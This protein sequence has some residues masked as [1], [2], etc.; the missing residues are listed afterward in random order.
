[1]VRVQV[2]DKV[3]CH[4]W[5]FDTAGEA[6]WSEQ[7]YGDSWRTARVHGEVKESL[8]RDGW[9][10]AWET[11]DN[12]EVRGKHLKVHERVAAPVNSGGASGS[13]AGGGAAAGRGG[14]GGGSAAA[15]DEWDSE[16]EEEE[17]PLFE[18]Q[19]AIRAADVEWKEQNKTGH[20]NFDQRAQTGFD[21]RGKA[22]LT[23][24]DYEDPGKTALDFFVHFFP[25][26]QLGP[27]CTKMTAAG[28]AKGYG[29]NFNV[30]KGVLLR[31]IGLWTSMCTAKLENR[32]AYWRK[33]TD[34]FLDDD[35]DLEGLSA[36]LD[37]GKYMSRNMF[38]KILSVFVLDTHPAPP[39]AAGTT[40]PD[41][42]HPVRKFFEQC[43][44]RCQE[45]LV[46]S[47][48]IVLDESMIPWLGRGMPGWMC[49]GRKPH[50]F[51]QEAKNGCDGETGIMICFEIYEAG[52]SLSSSFTSCFVSTFTL[53]LF[54]FRG[55]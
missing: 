23:M 2:G 17:D 48:L 5:L 26:E 10:V 54:V 50:P 44:K 40:D 47:W 38:D 37:Y 29:D 6:R 45:S 3:S 13:G 4:A 12:D 21:Q 46:P 16:V 19:P 42:F 18:D 31:W 30:T 14:A 32:R 34:A 35:E 41:P 55:V 49:V 1:M 20:V 51:G 9:L 11:G 39:A 8:A 7:I 33:Q 25:M 28:K 36:S 53:Q 22:R 52:G 15:E 24:D 27:M 43:N